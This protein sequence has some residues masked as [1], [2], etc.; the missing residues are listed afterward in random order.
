MAGTNHSSSTVA[1]IVEKY[2]EATLHFKFTFDPTQEKDRLNVTYVALDS[3]PKGTLKFISKGIL[4]NFHT[5]K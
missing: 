4:Q 5:S 3:Q 1:D 2:L